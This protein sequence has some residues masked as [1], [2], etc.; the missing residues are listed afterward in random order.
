[1][2]CA[3]CSR[4]PKTRAERVYDWIALPFIWLC[5]RFENWYFQ[6]PPVRKFYASQAKVKQHKYERYGQCLLLNDT[7]S[8]FSNIRPLSAEEEFLIKRQKQIE[9]IALMSTNP[10]GKIT[11]MRV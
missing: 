11:P 10:R 8:E 5:Q 2:V 9:E 1:M 6:P 7:N 4:R 3:G